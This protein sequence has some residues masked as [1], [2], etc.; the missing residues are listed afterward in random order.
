MFKP[1]DENAP[2]PALHIFSEARAALEA[3]H[4]ISS[5]SRARD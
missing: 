3:S 4:V 1:G 5:V 2:P